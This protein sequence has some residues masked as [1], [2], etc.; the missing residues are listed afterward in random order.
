MVLVTDDDRSCLI[1]TAQVRV[2]AKRSGNGGD[3]GTKRDQGSYGKLVL[4]F[5]CPATVPRRDG[6]DDD[7]VA[8]DM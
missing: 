4:H 1:L 8:C 3:D 5:K 7:E 6:D 2:F